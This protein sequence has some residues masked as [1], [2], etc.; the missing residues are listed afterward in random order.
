MFGERK[1]HST[2]DE[3]FLL[4]LRLDEQVS[5]KLMFGTRTL[6]SACVAVCD[7]VSSGNEIF[8][9]AHRPALTPGETNFLACENI[10]RIIS[11]SMHDFG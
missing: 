11:D 3:A 2:I 5:L 9:I 7:C 6:A 10:S 1:M 4:L 8:T